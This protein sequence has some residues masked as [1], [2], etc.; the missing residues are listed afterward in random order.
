MVEGAISSK[1]V[2]SPLIFQCLGAWE[3]GSSV[4]DPP[5]GRCWLKLSKKF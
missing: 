1:G 3:S 5:F 2:G 4:K